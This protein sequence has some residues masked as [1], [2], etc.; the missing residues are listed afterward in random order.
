MNKIIVLFVLFGQGLIAQTTYQ[1]VYSIFQSS[2]VS[3][4]HSGASPSGNLDLSGT[5]SQVY[6]ALINGIPTNPFAASKGY[7][8]IYPGFPEQSFL[9]RKINNGLFQHISLQ[10]SE[11]SVMPLYQPTLSNYEVDLINAWILRGAPQNGTIQN[12]QAIYDYYNGFGMQSMSPPPAPL[13]S[14]GIQIHLGAIFLNPLEE[15]EFLK[16]HRVDIPIESEVNRIES[17][18]NTF[19]HHYIMYKFKDSVSAAGVSNSLRDINNLFDLNNNAKFIAT[20]QFN[21]DLQLPENTGYFWEK[22]PYLDLN[23]HIKNYSS[24]SIMRAEVYSNIYFKPRG[25]YTTEMKTELITYPEVPLPYPFSDFY[26]LN[27]N[28]DTV[29]TGHIFDNSSSDSIYIWLLSS[30]THKYGKD[31]DIYARNADGSKGTQL[32]EGFYNTDYTFNQG[33]YDYTHPPIRYFEPLLGLNF[34]EGITHEATYRNN[35]SS[36]VTW[37]LT[38]DDEMML[39]IIQYTESR[40]ILSNLDD[41]IPLDNNINIYPNPTNHV[42][43]IHFK[44]QFYGDI[45]LKDLL[46][47]TIMNQKNI[48]KLNT[49]IFDVSLIP[50]GVYFLEFQELGNNNISTLKKVIIQ[51]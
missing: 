24:D 28:T 45:K 6:N 8:L 3:A 21:Y 5:E 47:K 34:G 48:E 19:S 51:H 38:T 40:P 2:C 31:Y 42:I 11:G 37:G 23:Y 46:G 26:I 27:N 20:W 16:K 32:Y 49:T 50:N 15:V 4:C 10:P 39:M 1:K 35:G 36:A 43:N 25:L 9:F 13:P 30:H 33:Y 7:K 14:E 29:F 18:I 17:F 41:N 22:N 12:E 44:N